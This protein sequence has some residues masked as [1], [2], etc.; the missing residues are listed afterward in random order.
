MELR[1]G[2]AARRALIGALA[3]LLAAC[4]PYGPV[5][6]ITWGEMLAAMVAFFVMFA[7]F[8]IFIALFADILR[9]PALSGGAKALWVLVL[10]ILP[11]VGSL[12]YIVMRPKEPI[13]RLPM[14]DSDMSAAE[15]FA[16]L[17]RMKATGK[18]TDAEYEE[19]RRMAGR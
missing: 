7:A 14:P 13:A 18:I 11:I 4:S 2:T 3:L 8:V 1:I 6:T 12:I 19:Y 16:E 15:Q 5:Q 9:S 17:D 10:V